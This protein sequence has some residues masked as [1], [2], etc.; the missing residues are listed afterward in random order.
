MHGNA[1]NKILVTDCKN[2]RFHDQ[3]REGKAERGVYRSVQE[4]SDSDTSDESSL[5][6]SFKGCPKIEV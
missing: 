2:V 1:Q 6:S 4:G 5:S 3:E